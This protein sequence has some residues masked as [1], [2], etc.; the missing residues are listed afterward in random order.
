MPQD[1]TPQKPQTIQNMFNKIAGKYDLANSVLS[2]GTHL[3][4][5]KKLIKAANLQPGQRALDCATGTGDIAFMMEKAAV[6]KADITAI[7]FSEEMLV[8]ARER[9]KKAGSQVFFKFADV[10]N[11]PFPNNNFD[12]ATISFGLRNVSNMKSALQE[13]ARVVK[14]DGKV[15]VLEFGQPTLPIIKTIYNFYS[16]TILPK[17]GG[18]ISGETEAYTYLHQSSSTFPC[19]EHFCNLAKGTGSYSQCDFKAFSFG[20]AYLYSLRVNN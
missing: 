5:K 18:M 13:L 3:L 1:I 16:G 6:G 2:L 19:G 14:P 15:I 20:V 17:L 9:G 11:L 12:V 4:W 8:V 10:E 7:D